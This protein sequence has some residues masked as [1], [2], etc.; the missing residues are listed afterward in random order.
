[1]MGVIDLTSHD[2]ALLVYL[3]VSNFKLVIESLEGSLEYSL[4]VK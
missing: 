4:D 3:D 2:Y 1:M